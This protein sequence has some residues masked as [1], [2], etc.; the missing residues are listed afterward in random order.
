MLVVSAITG[1][2]PS[3]MDI[4]PRRFGECLNDWFRSLGKN[5]KP[6]LLSSLAVHIPLGIVLIFIFW[7]TGAADSFALYLDPEALETMSDAEIFDEFVPVL[8]VIGVWTILQV[9]AGVFVYLAASRTV[10]V[11]M[12]GS[13]E[14]WVAVSRHAGRRT[15]TGIAAALLVAIGAA[16]LVGVAVFVGWSAFSSGGVGFFTVFLTTTVALT[17]LVVLMWLG[18]SLAFLTQVIAMEDSGPTRA[19]RK[20]F[21]LVQGR[22][23]ATLGYTLLVSLIASAASQVLG[24]VLTPLFLIGTVV[25]EIWPIVFSLSTVLQG[26]LFAAI[27]AGYAIWYVDLRARG[28]TLTTEQLV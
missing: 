21:E 12:A 10:A 20:S 23:W 17:V 2:R 24:L 18:V 8:W 11:D 15:G 1:Y 25:P 28:E 19:L 9:L 5:W 4:P 3:A 13:E 6:L 27:G 14:S 7:I 22:W 26:P 16:V